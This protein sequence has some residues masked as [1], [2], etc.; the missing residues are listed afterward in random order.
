MEGGENTQ[1][2]EMSE[3][4]LLMSNIN[5]QTNINS[6]EWEESHLPT[7]VNVYP[8][9]PLKR[10]LLGGKNMKQL[11]KASGIELRR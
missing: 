5:D 4:T 2:R 3:E 7:P 8:H 9:V 1:G 10:N 11:T 6:G